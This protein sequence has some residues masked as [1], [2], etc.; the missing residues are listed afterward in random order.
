M[1]DRILTIVDAAFVHYLLCL[2]GQEYCQGLSI[3]SPEAVDL[4]DTKRQGSIQAVGL[5]PLKDCHLA[6][7][8]LG[9][10]LKSFSIEIQL[11]FAI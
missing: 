1:R 7:S 2:E 11:L 3:K 9:D 4:P 5:L 6:V 10:G 8:S